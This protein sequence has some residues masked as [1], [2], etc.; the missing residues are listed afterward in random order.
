MKKSL[1]LLLILLTFPVLMAVSAST[2]T[3][4]D[5]GGILYTEPV[6]SVLFS[7]KIH[8]D[9]K[10]ISCDRCHSGLFDMEALKVQQKKDF[11]MESLYK[12]K[13]CGA[14]HNGKAAFASDT[15]CARCHVRADGLKVGY[16][17]GKAPAGGAVYKTTVMMGTGKSAVRF[18]HETHISQAKC[19]DCHSGLFKIKKGSNHIAMNDHGSNKYC[20][21]CHDGRKAFSWNEC[22]HC[23]AI[24]PAPSQ[25]IPFGKGEKAVSF[26][27]K[28]HSGSLP[29][30]SCHTKL[31]P[32][33]KGGEKITFADHSSGKNCFAC[34]TGKGKGA[35]FYDCNRC[36]KDQAAAAPSGP[37]QAILFGAGAKAVSF[38]HKSH[39]GTL[40][41]SSCHTKLFPYKK[42]GEKITFA[43][44]SGGKNCFVCH[45][46]KGK[47]AAFYDCNRCHKDRAAAALPDR[48]SSCLTC[49][50]SDSIMKSMVKPPNIPSEGE[51]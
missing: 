27:H 47:G 43:D 30:S 16:A 31:F 29:C 6:K 13:Y 44:H 36:H 23:H 5:G 15:Q 48:K 1:V 14:C 41:C 28:S 11:T 38:S 9:D 2:G 4:S 49:H 19:N 21:G 7:H 18:N 50:T 35:A 42:G 25:T 12:G 3:F 26:N 17:Q 32:Y 39:S 24:V 8:A 22:N 10:R 33:K 37:S 34:H 20:F 45:T 40:E 46:G 51:G